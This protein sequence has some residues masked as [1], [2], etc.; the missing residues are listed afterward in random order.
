MEWG[1]A[2]PVGIP[3]ALMRKPKKPGGWERRLEDGEAG[4]ILAHLLPVNWIRYRRYDAKLCGY[5]SAGGTLQPIDE[6]TCYRR[7]LITRVGE[8]D[9]LLKPYS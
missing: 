2:L 5:T 8:I 9:K 6:Q 3:T 7:L 4:V 1:I